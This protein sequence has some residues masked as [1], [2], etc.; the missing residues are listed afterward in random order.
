MIKVAYQT[1]RKIN[2]ISSFVEKIKL[3]YRL[4]FN[5]FKDK[6]IQQN[7]TSNER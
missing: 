4:N 6:T 5:W 3:N 2:G 1:N 7:H